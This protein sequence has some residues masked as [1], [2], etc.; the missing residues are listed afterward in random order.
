MAGD[1]VF[2]VGTKKVLSVIEEKCVGR[3]VNLSRTF[4]KK[5]ANQKAPQPLKGLSKT[6]KT[7]RAQKFGPKVIPSK[8]LK[9]EMKPLML[10]EIDE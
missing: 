10:I 1:C 6:Q 8:E 2:S 5:A 3:V 7:K 9:L 4:D